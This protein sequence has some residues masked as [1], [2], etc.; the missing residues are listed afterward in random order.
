MTLVVGELRN[1]RISGIADSRLT[2]AFGGHGDYFEGA[3]KIVIISP[4]LWV[5]FAGRRLLAD[6]LRSI[7]PDFEQAVVRCRELHADSD[8]HTDLLLANALGP[9]LVRIRSGSIERGLI[10]A[11]IGDQN[12]F[13]AFQE[14]RVGLRENGRLSA[15][16]RGLLR[17]RHI[18]SVGEFAVSVI[19]EPD[20]F[21]YADAAHLIGGFVPQSIPSGVPTILQ[22]GNA[23]TGGFALA[24]CSAGVGVSAVGIYLRHARAGAIYQ[25]LERDEAV[26]IRDVDGGGF[27]AAARGLGLAL[28]HPMN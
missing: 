22:F 3:L 19:T 15:A 7:P 6:A 20:G 11:S 10:D 18:A 24:I 21:S 28:A 13:E 9:E 14:I 2:G 25:P 4:K 1:G 16:M 8:E 5:A 27:V 12:A 17:D 26:I 23:A